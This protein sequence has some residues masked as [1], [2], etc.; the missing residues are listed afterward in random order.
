MPPSPALSQ[1]LDRHLRGTGVTANCLHPG[2][3]ATRF[4]DQSGAFMSRVV[5]LAKFFAMS[6]AKG[7]QTIVYLASSPDVAKTTGKYFYES[8]PAIPS[9]SAQDDRSAL[10]LWQRS[11]AL[12]GMTE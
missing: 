8:V 10:L 9:P 11:A 6:P 2:F 12:A 5:W 4:G 3:V 7:A 1:E